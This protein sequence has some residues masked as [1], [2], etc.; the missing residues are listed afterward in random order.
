MWQLL[1]N[2]R[3]RPN[4]REV[5]DQFMHN[6]RAIPAVNRICAPIEG[7][8]Q[9][10]THAQ[11]IWPDK[12]APCGRQKSGV[13][14]R[15]KNWLAAI[16]SRAQTSFAAPLTKPEVFAGAGAPIDGENLV[17]STSFAA[18]RR[19]L[20]GTV[21][22]IIERSTSSPK[23]PPMSSLR[24]LNVVPL[25]LVL[26]TFALA[27]EKK[28][29]EPK[30]DVIPHAQDKPPGPALSP[31][32]ALKKMKVPEGFAVELVASE[33]DII[34]PVAMTIDERGR[35]WITESLEYPRK[36]A[37]PG[38]DRVKVCEDSD[39]DGKFDKFTIFAEGLNIPSGIAVGH[40]GVWVANSPDI[41]FLQDTDNDGKADRQ[42]VVV[43]GFGRDDTHELPNSLTWGP[44]GYLY[45]LNG[46]F[47][48]SVVK[49]DGKTFDFTCALFR[50]HPQTRKFEIFCEGT[51]NPWGVTFDGDGSA[52]V[53]ACVIDHLWHLTET[54]YYH[55]QGGPYPQ[56]TWK[57]DS[58]VKH[59]HQ[60]AA[61][62][63]IHYYDSDAYPEQ[64]RG[65]L[66]M[67][68]LHGSC[69][70][71]DR[72]SRD[73]STYFGEGEPDFLSADDAWFMPVSQK[74]GP[75][76]CLYV[77][78]WYDRY[79]CYQD[80][81]RDPEGIDR[82]R[83]RL[84]RVRY[85]DTPRAKPFDLSKESDE[86]L[87]ERLKSGNGYLRD[88]AQRLLVER[89]YNAAV[90]RKPGGPNAIRGPLKHLIAAKDTPHR[91][92]MHAL[93][94]YI[95]AGPLDDDDYSFLL[96]HPEPAVRAWAVRAAGNYAAAVQ[97]EIPGKIAALAADKSSD[98]R[99]QVAIAARKI[100]GLDPIP[101]LVQVLANSGD[102]KLIPHIVWQN[103]HPLLE[104]DAAKF[105]VEVKK[106][107]IKSSPAMGEIM[108]RATERI[109]ANKK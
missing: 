75:D 106:I 69:I 32:E 30:K 80:A 7:P 1:M 72:L 18:L 28:K 27:Q 76:G 48:H 66:F 104:R 46:V 10:C 81:G 78:D 65:Q 109:L 6:T 87:L 56:F 60:K 92:R 9:A 52:F 21:P 94:T 47:N 31:Q 39:A 12:E 73:G 55:R 84:Y 43:T 102:D 62:C 59:K 26:A 2:G 108:K 90:P 29:D 4:D 19:L 35:F 50:I 71:V 51:S 33:P 64:Y 8:R 11:I 101:L 74:T 34:N 89:T 24:K 22:F 15:A 77:L 82:L 44:D 85:K 103:L 16:V 14:R 98:V 20:R 91:T 42:E 95:S 57:I 17:V 107:D 88:V 49:Q 23:A 79:H 86:Q 99:L 13:V 68:N 40:G 37:G 25:L 96:S 67:G 3:R 53:S 105:L 36:S 38:K 93:F 97:R 100:E 45:G 70:N 63:G 5:V 61:Y 41:L 54:G 83:G 58:I